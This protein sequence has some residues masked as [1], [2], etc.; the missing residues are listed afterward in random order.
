MFAVCLVFTTGYSC[1]KSSDRNIKMLK[2]FYTFYISTIADTSINM[3]G[4]VVDKKLDSIK[5]KYCTKKAL[6][7]IDSLV[8]VLDADPIIQAHDA[9]Y[10][11]LNTLAIDKDSGKVNQYTVTYNNKDSLNHETN[12]FTIHLK[13]VNSKIDNISG[14]WQEVPWN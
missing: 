5:Y 4:T 14:K 3:T 7:Q 1:K 10:E 6:K 11:W 2:N 13:V 12:Y 9:S 8:D